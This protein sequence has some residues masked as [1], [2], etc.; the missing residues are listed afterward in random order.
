[1]R[2]RPHLAVLLLAGT[3][4]VAQEATAPVDAAMTPAE[5][6]TALDRWLAP[7]AASGTF[8]GVVLVARDGKVVFERAYGTADRERG[9]PMSTDLRFSLASIGKAFTKVAI[10]QL[11]Q[12]GKL[13]FTDTIGSVLPDYPNADA[14][15]AT[16]AQ[17][18]NHTGGVVDFFG[19]EF[20]ATPK[21]RFRSND[22]YFAFVA[23][24][25]L[26]FPPGTRNQYCNGCY[27]VL[28]EIVAKMA[29]MPYE[30]YVEEHVFGRAGMRTAGFLSVGDPDVARPYTRRRGDGTNPVPAVGLHGLRG[31]A[32]GGAFARAADLLAFDR[33]AR[34]ERLLNAVMT[35]W[36]YD[37]VSEEDVPAALKRGTASG[38]LRGLGIAGGAPGMNANLEAGPTWTIV[39]AGNLDP[40]NAGRI[41][42]AIRRAL[43]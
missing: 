21:E 2:L 17:L 23:P 18:L 32:A 12:G 20:D 27:I 25:P 7:Q 4:L 15:G 6:G 28:G 29:G 8:A 9:T 26:L 16:V 39:V 14:R 34:S 13:R 33:A 19:P 43:R 38:G 3:G 10:G 35:D 42:S 1:M 5:L 11:V 30:R 37:N 41:A 22:D 36:F 24:R 31:S 40:P